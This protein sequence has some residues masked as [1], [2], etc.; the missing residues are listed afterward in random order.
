MLVLFQF[1]S[2]RYWGHHRGALALSAL[3][4]ALGIAVFTAIQIANHSVFAAFESSLEAVS[5]K[6]T[7]Q[8]SAGTGGFSEDVYLKIRRLRDPKIQALSPVLSR[9]FFSPTLDTSLLV[10][11]GDV[12]TEA[13]FRDFRLETE[14][15]TTSSAKSTSE[16]TSESTSADPRDALRLL[17]DPQAIAIGADLAARHQLQ[18]GSV[19]E[20]FVGAKREQF[21]VSS[22]LTGDALEQTYGGDFAFLDIA[23]AQE[24]FELLG[25][26][27]RIDLRVDERDIP[28]VLKRLKP[29][30][31]PDATLQRP[32]QR[33]AEVGAMLSAFRLNLSALSCIAVFVGAFLIYN[34][35]A[36]AVVQR[37][38]EVGVLRSIGTSQKQLRTLFL[39]EAAWIGFLGSLGGLLLG[40]LLA[41]SALQAVSTTVSA[42]YIAV[43]AR[44]I[45]VPTWLIFGAPLCGTVLAVLSAIPPAFEAASTSPRAAS[46]DI[47]L[48]HT[49]TRWAWPL[50]AAGAVLL[51]LAIGLSSPVIAARSSLLGFGATF[52]TLGG[53]ALISPLFT[54]GF[55]HAI[56]QFCARVFGVEGI[57]AAT[58]LQ[59]ALNRSSLVV[60]A[61][62]VALSMTIGLAVMVGS[63]RNSVEKWVETTLTGD[64]YIAPA[65]GFSGDSGPGLPPE[66]LRFIETHPGIKVFDTIRGAQ[67]IINNQPVFIAANELPALTTGDRELEF[68]DTANGETA[69][70]ASQHEGTGIL[71]SERFK[72]LIGFGSGETIS[73][74]T[75]SGK[76]PFFIAG[77]FYDYTPDEAVIYLPKV[78]YERYWKDEAVDALSLYLK[79]D[80]PAEKLQQELKSRFDEKYQL[81]LA[82]N[83]ELRATVFRTFDQTFAV[84]YALQFIA[85]VIAAIG[86][87]E[88]ISSLLLE[89][90]RELATLRA[91]GASKGQMM[92]TILIE[93]GLIGICGWLMSLAAGFVLAWQLIFVINRQFFGWTI[94]WHVPYSVPLQAF[95]IAIL[96]AVGAGILPAWRIVRRSLATA[97]QR[98]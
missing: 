25:K 19:L 61:L 64:L 58:Q 17:T 28:A 38:A 29:L 68:I 36:S 27:S 93:C 82:P 14:Q 74:S 54:L 95:L 63:F 77:V 11:G 16:S 45:L 30:L 66:V 47:T 85:V 90:T 76:K 20:L 48:H 73:L 31:P 97:L 50:A 51:L 55:S 26:L 2:L 75:P 78:L 86:I 56:R 69:A 6:S 3:G 65:N 34:A 46:N 80:Y 33:G 24:K 81:T 70:L 4:V 49:T 62:M 52:C 5:G 35:I 96:A 91:L 42:L 8:I 60:A 83:H 7:L 32:A 18:V 21:R 22:I 23:T 53:F 39:F 84:T 43:K 57:L 37:R 15:K 94:G 67:T 92:R 71:V 89:R 10:F 12:F 87:F 13:Q 72:N 79:P 41:H 1:L 9:T 59:R 44:E 88:I 98:E 40:I